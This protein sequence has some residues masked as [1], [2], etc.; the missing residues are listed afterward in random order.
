MLVLMQLSL[1]S[2]HRAIS[3]KQILLRKAYMA[4]KAQLHSFLSKPIVDL[5]KN[6][7]MIIII[8]VV[9]ISEIKLMIYFF[10]FTLL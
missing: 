4:D 3:R 6:Y 1:N 9:I 2:S 10:C 5:K 7:S 8:I